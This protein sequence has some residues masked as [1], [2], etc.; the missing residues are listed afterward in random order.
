MIRVR[1]NQYGLNS[2]ET[3]SFSLSGADLGKTQDELNEILESCYD[4]TTIEPR[5]G[6][7]EL[8][9]LFKETYLNITPTVD[10]PPTVINDKPSIPIND[11]PPAFANKPAAPAAPVNQEVDTVGYVD[12]WFKKMNISFN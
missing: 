5:L 9:K 2:Y 3:S 12:D 11:E 1:K 8:T 7:D 6:F 10:A 4:V